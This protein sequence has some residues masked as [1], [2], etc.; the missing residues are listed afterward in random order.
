LW[1]EEAVVTS[2]AP[3][4]RQVSDWPAV[5]VALGILLLLGAVL[6]T[7]TAR[8]TERDMRDLLAGLAPVLGV[9]TGAF[10]TYFFTRQA[11]A[12]AQSMAASASRQADSVQVRFDSQLQRTR[13]LHNALSTALAMV[14]T[15]TAGRMRQDPTIRAALGP[16][17]PAS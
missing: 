3:G 1:I 14:D 11:T 10:V 9:V 7:A 5:V 17:E 13:S 15:E 8:W 2:S 16:V 4:Q 12:T 6:V